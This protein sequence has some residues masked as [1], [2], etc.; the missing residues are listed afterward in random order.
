[1]IWVLTVYIW[2]LTSSKIVNTSE[3]F[4]ER[5]KIQ[6]QRGVKG[7]FDFAM[8][9]ICGRA[10]TLHQSNPVAETW[11]I[12]G[13]CICSLIVPNQIGLQDRVRQSFLG[14]GPLNLNTKIDRKSKIRLCQKY[15]YTLVSN[16][17]SGLDISRI[18]QISKLYSVN[19]YQRFLM[20]FYQ[21]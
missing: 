10:C 17:V 18:W 9:R 16:L 19:S 20:R 14:N 13:R 7:P 4:S 5:K 1:M 12:A 6:C 15:I 2:D 3:V 8:F 11:L 21:L